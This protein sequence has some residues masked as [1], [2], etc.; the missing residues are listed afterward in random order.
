M[1]NL[2]GKIVPKLYHSIAKVRFLL[3]DENGLL[4]KGSAEGKSSDSVV[5]GR[6]SAAVVEW[7]GALIPWWGGEE[8]CY[9]GAGEKL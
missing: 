8:L 2:P 3:K 5:K 9:H 4:V 1:L 6:S 7:G